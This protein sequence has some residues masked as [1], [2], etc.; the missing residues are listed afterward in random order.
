MGRILFWALIGIL[1]SIAYRS[2]GHGAASRRSTPGAARRDASEAM[3]A[4]AVC[5]LH[6]PRSEAIQVA[7]GG[8]SAP[9]RWF[10][11]EEHR[12]LGAG[13]R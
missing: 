4:C 13:S 6:V 5:G 1:V 11:S 10:C 8:A 9:A 7:G 2:L 3:V 12:R